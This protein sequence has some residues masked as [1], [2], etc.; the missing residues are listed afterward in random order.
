M[1]NWNDMGPGMGFGIGFGW[2]FGLLSLVLLVLAIAALIK[3]L[4]KQ[5]KGVRNDLHDQSNDPRRRVR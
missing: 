3:Y 1:M 5:E 4:R 2:L